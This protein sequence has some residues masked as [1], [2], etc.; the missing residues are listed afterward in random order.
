EPAEM[1]RATMAEI[2][3]ARGVFA[4]AFA[5]GADAPRGRFACAVTA[6]PSVPVQPQ[7]V[8]TSPLEHGGHPIQVSRPVG[9]RELLD[10]IGIALGL[11]Q[12]APHYTLEASFGPSSGALRLLLVDDNDVNREVVAEMLHRLGHEVTLAENGEQALA[13]LGSQSFDAVFMDVQLPGIDGLEVTRRFRATSPATP[14]IGLTAHTSRQDRDRCLAAGMTS[15]LSKPVIAQHLESA[16]A[17]VARRDAID[18]ATGGN[19]ALLARVRDAFARQTPE[20]LTGIRDALGRGDAEALAR[21]AH[22]LKGSLSYFGG[23]AVTFAREVEAAA[24]AGELTKAAALLPDLE[25]AVAA[26]S[27]RLGSATETNRA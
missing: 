19:P 13:I 8:I 2:L 22:K 25:I 17:S 21:H 7:V 14:V 18:E 26:V 16:L 24:K 27:R 3:R 11:T 23:N 4:S 5:R 6:D 10:A 9:E 12:H 1:A 20:L 15:V